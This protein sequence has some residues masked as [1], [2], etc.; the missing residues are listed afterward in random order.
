MLSLVCGL[1]H[2]KEI[3]LLASLHSCTAVNSTFKS[4]YA[5]FSALGTTF[6]DPQPPLPGQHDL[7]LS[8]L[9]LSSSLQLSRHGLSDLFVQS[10]ST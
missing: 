4:V 9:E 8:F 6:G 3:T 10:A 7:M 5:E 2:S 1:F